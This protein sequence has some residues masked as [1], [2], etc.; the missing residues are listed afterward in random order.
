MEEQ[1]SNKEVTLWFLSVIDP[2]PWLGVA[3]LCVLIGAIGDKV[4]NVTNIFRIHGKIRYEV[5][6]KGIRTGYSILYST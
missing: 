5:S 3:R 2:T 6:E 4:W 1:K